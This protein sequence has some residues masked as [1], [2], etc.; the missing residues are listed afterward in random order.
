M[1]IYAAPGSKIVFTGEGGR[2]AERALARRLLT[3]GQAYTVKYTNVLNWSTEV[4]LEETDDGPFNSVMF[5]DV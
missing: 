1:N 4:Y 2:D 3:V 5:E